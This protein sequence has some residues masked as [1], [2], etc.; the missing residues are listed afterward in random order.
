MCE[1]Y[2]ANDRITALFTRRY[3]V[4]TELDGRKFI[5]LND[6]ECET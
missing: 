2:R 6:L 5:D 1:H 4:F 3:P